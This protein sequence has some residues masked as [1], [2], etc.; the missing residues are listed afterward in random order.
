MKIE[1]DA[2]YK[3]MSKLAYN[4]SFNAPFKGVEFTEKDINTLADAINAYDIEHG[5]VM[6]EPTQADIDEHER[7]MSNVTSTPNNSMIELEKQVRSAIKDWLEPTSLNVAERQRL[8]QLER[9]VAVKDY[10]YKAMADNVS[11]EWIE[12]WF[13]E[14]WYD[15]NASQHLCNKPYFDCGTAFGA[16]V[17]YALKATTESE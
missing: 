2:E 6:S 12:K 1:T 9:L 5:Y 17:Q 14:W 11:N 10:F 8:E 7:D 16:G 3:L 15:N 13:K 4:L